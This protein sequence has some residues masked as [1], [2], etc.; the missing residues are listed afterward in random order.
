MNESERAKGQ[1]ILE[2]LITTLRDGKAKTPAGIFTTIHAHVHEVVTATLARLGPEY[3][4][5]DV[6]EV[7][8]MFQ[9]SAGLAQQGNHGE[10]VQPAVGDA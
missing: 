3:D 6:L 4:R 5:A 9:L 2:A 7:W 10:S 8:L 1:A